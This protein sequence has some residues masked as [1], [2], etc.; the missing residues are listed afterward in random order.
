MV[1]VAVAFSEGGR[2][3]WR[4]TT[5]ELREGGKKL[6]QHSRRAILG[7]ER[8]AARCAVNGVYMA[9]MCGDYEDKGWVGESFCG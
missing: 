4:T 9:T 2:K 1:V 7:G 8:R 5:C 3:S 6:G